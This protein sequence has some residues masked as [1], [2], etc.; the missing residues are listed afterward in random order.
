M[1]RRNMEPLE[2]R[3]RQDVETCSILATVPNAVTL[4][5]HQHM[6]VILDPDGCDLSLDPGIKGGG[7]GGG[8][9]YDA[10]RIGAMP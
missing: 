3:Q 5:V 8:K 7:C 9:P 2:G 6:P 10:Q 1:V 4:A